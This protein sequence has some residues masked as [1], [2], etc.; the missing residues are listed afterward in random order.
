MGAPS[1][2]HAT[3]LHQ[4]SSVTVKNTPP[5]QEII[6]WYVLVYNCM[7]NYTPITG[8]WCVNSEIYFSLPK[9]F[10]HIFNC[11]IGYF[12]F[13]SYC[14]SSLLYEYCFILHM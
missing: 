8:D 7:S 9:K 3:K 4:L 10:S 13:I 12:S 14:F 1:N 6:A 5:L 2:D 11:H